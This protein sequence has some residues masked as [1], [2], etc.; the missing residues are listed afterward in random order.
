[1]N[2]DIYWL[3]D[4]CQDD[5]H[6]LQSALEQF[7]AIAESAKVEPSGGSLSVFQLQLGAVGF[8]VFAGRFGAGGAMLA[9]LT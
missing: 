3:K 4:K 7:T 5:S 9:I 2:R 6:D 8:E 1:V